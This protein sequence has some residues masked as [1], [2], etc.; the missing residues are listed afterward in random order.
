MGI[1]HQE[2]MLLKI[3]L[4]A[5]PVF[6]L[7]IFCTVTAGTQDQV[8]VM[9]NH[10]VIQSITPFAKTDITCSD[11]DLKKN[12]GETNFC[13]LQKTLLSLQSLVSL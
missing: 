8:T 10:S 11:S 9:P 4:G 2:K 13:K 6:L 1:T 3:L 12:G 5:R 7:H